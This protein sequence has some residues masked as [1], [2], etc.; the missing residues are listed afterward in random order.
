MFRKILIAVAI[1]IAA[2]SF[3]TA[4]L[5]IQPAPEANYYLAGAILIAIASA[6]Y[7]R[8]HLVCAI[9]SGSLTG[10]FGFVWATHHGLTNVAFT[11]AA[12]VICGFASINSLACLA[13]DQKVRP[14]EDD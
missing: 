9:A 8:D 10:I 4:W 14:P 11:L 13:S 2:S 6:H 1:V 5:H 3:L 12:T 7:I